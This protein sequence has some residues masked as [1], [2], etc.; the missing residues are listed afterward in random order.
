MRPFF[1]CEYPAQ[2]LAN[3]I[4]FVIV[5]D[6]WEDSFLFSSLRNTVVAAMEIDKSD[7]DLIQTIRVCNC[8]KGNVSIYV[9]ALACLL[10]PVAE[11]YYNEIIT[12][13]SPLYPISETLT[14]SEQIKIN[15]STG[16]STRQPVS[17]ISD[18]KPNNGFMHVLIPGEF[19]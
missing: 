13:G 8:K 14:A 12:F 17:Q 19:H 11:K 5:D 16:S 4:R 18:E 15:V 1:Y 6:A 10:G 3:M 7:S 2:L 9:Q